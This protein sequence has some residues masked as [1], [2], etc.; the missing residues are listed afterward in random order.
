MGW[1]CPSCRHHVYGNVGQCW[2]CH[3]GVC[4]YCKINAG[5]QQHHVSYDPEITVEL[6]DE[7]HEKVHYPSKREP[8]DDHDLLDRLH[9]GE[10]RKQAKAAGAI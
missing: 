1:K 2:Y 10:T 8:E 9:P 7:C 3:R 4:D 6:C 5:E